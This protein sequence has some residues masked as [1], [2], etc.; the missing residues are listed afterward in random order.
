MIEAINIPIYGQGIDVSDE[1]PEK[2]KSDYK[3]VFEYETQI[4]Y[5]QPGFLRRH[6]LR[7]SAYILRIGCAN[8]A[9]YCWNIETTKRLHIWWVFLFDSISAIVNKGAAA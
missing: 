1:M 6:R 5:Y 3:A 4:L 8:D 2:Y 9:A 7:M